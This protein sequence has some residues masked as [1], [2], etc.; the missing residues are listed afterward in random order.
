MQNIPLK[1]KQ[2]QS[3]SITNINSGG[4]WFLQ[5]FFKINL[6][7][8]IANYILNASL[9]KFIKTRREILLLDQTDFPDVIIKFFVLSN[10]KTIALLTWV[11]IET[12]RL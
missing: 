12:V 9:G 11:Y 6:L 4:D 2:Q 10:D 3:V 7:L 1:V 8:I 5:P